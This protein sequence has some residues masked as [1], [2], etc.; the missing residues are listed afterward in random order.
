MAYKIGQL[1]KNEGVNYLEEAIVID[2]DI[3][4]SYENSV[5]LPGDSSISFTD[6]IIK[7]ANSNAFIASETYYLSFY[8]NRMTIKDSDNNDIPVSF[9]FDI[10]LK[11]ENVETG[12]G[13]FYQYIRTINIEQGIKENKAF[14]NIIFTPND[15]YESIV[16]TVLRTQS[17]L[18]DG[19]KKQMILSDVNLQK[20]VNLQDGNN[21]PKNIEKIGIQAPSGLLFTIN[22][23]EMIIGRTGIYELYNKD[24]PITYLGFV[25]KPNDDNFFIIDYQYD[26]S[27]K[28]GNV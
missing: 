28:E 11:K 23:E 6:C 20:I 9:S 4:N 18:I 26:D 12:T 1:I 7:P 5:I 14:V 19:R 22:G 15:T 3:L 21:L 10:N 27:E 2:K 8:V 13:H 24:I 17:D 16:L 25:T